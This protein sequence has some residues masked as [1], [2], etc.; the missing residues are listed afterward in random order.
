VVGVGRVG[1][2][3]EEAYEPL[4]EL[5]L[6]EHLGARQRADARDDRVTVRAASV[7][8]RGQPVAPQ[9]A[10]RCVQREAARAA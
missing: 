3:I 8:Q 10:Q 4:I 1:P 9:L 6:P 7:D 5:G 2:R